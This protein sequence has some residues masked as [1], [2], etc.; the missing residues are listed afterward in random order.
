[1]A[2]KIGPYV[3]KDSVG[4]GGQG[5]VVR[6]EKINQ[7]NTE[8]ALKRLHGASDQELGRFRDELEALRELDHP[9]IVTLVD[10]DFEAG[11]PYIV[12]EYCEHG[13]LAD[14]PERWLNDPVKGLEVFQR[15]VDAVGA[16]HREDVVHRDIKPENVLLRDQ[17]TPVVADF[18]I[19]YWKDGTRHTLTNE[20]VGA[21]FYIAPE[22]EDGRAEEVKPVSDIYSLGKLLYWMLSGGE[23][24]AR[25]RHRYPNNNL[26]SVAGNPALEY[27]NRLL[28]KMITQDRSERYSSTGPVKRDVEAV[29]E[30]VSGGYRVVK[31][32]HT[33]KCTFCGMGEYR[34]R[35]NPED[36]AARARQLGQKV[37]GDA[38]WAILVCDACGHVQQFRADVA[39]F[40]DWWEEGT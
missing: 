35:V 14:H 9:N 31:R 10:H 36:G 6:V 13:S 26:V 21:R 29:T 4:G 40:S 33:P 28:D 17:T 11:T 27:V 25:E 18:G 15:V 32:G 8:Y 39:R 3:V 30:V 24:F 7:P 1:M 5:S 38:D 34:W 16:A 23:I 12:M 2:E 37:V 20:Q 19:C 22:L